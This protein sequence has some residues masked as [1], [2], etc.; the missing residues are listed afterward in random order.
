MVKKQHTAEEQGEMTFFEH[1][2]AL[3]PHLMRGVSAL[4]VVAVA[5]FC[6][7]TW[8]I[9]YFLF[10]PAQPDFPT[11]RLLAWF[12]EVLG[13]DSFQAGYTNFSLINTKLAGQFSL[14][15]TV[16]LVA[17]L[18]VTIPYL[19]WEIW[20]FI[21]PGLTWYERRNTHM[22]VFYV[23]LCFFVG[24]GFGYFIV[25]PLAINF[26]TTWTASPT[27]ANMVD[28]NSFLRSVLSTSLACGLIFQ[29]P[30]MMYFL[31]RMGIV[32]AVF[33]RKYRKHAIVILAV[34]SAAITPPDLLSMFL[35]MLPLILLYE[36]SIKIA[37]RVEKAKA[38]E[39]EM[40]LKNE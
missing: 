15:M 17:G 3:R 21:R 40:L 10:G 18:I 4:L 31:T 6:L 20:R 13:N 22:F 7:K 30:V 33:L 9:D 23:S 38:A 5:A 34:I 1:L 16:S 24:V 8:I 2:D 32:N 26:F 36:L 19:L 35:V 29:L 37:V 27:I 28:I 11:N 14:T 25:S 39:E 12:G